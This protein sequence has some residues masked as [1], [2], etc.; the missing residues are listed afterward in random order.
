VA[1]LH[2][3]L[4]SGSTDSPYKGYLKAFIFKN[5]VFSKLVLMKIQY[6]LALLVFIAIAKYYDRNPN[7]STEAI[8]EKNYKSYKLFVKR[9]AFH[10][11]LFQLTFDSIM[12]DPSHN[13]VHDV[14]KY[15]LYNAVSLD[16]ALTI[17]LF[18]ELEYEGF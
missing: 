4:F 1:N 14:E 15:N 9:G 6:P 8:N 16:S 13:S 7:V 12:F 11:D 5:F 18:K 10:D 2:A 17:N 3:S